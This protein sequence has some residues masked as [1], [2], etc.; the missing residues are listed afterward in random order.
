MFSKLFI[1]ASLLASGIAYAPNCKVAHDEVETQVCHIQPTQVCGVEADDAV[2][3]QHIEPDTLTVDVVD[4]FCVP[5]VVAA[6]GCTDVTRKIVLST[7]KV[8]DT[9]SG[10]IP[11]PYAALCR[12]LPKAVCNPVPH[13]LPKTVCEPVELPKLVYYHGYY[14]K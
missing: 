4:T 11:A 10:P 12:I 5:A 6:D 13:K 14:G 9:P 3:F 1:F 8:V 7:A 2:V